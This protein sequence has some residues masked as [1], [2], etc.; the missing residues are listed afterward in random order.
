MNWF[1]V[2]KENKLISQN[3]TH[4]KVDENEPEQRD[5]RCKE[6][7]RKIMLKAKVEWEET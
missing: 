4:T 1:E 3:I 6:K 5:E 7:L 2:I